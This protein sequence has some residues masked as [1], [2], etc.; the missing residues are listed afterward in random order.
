MEDLNKRLIAVE[1]RITYAERTISDLSDVLR[2]LGEKI[3]AQERLIAGLRTATDQLSATIEQP[4]SLADE[5]PPH[6]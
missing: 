1:E 4:R 3:D 2:S 5:K 6:Y